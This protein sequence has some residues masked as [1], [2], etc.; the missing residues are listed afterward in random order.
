MFRGV[1]MVRSIG[2]RI[3]IALV[4]G[5][6]AAGT[7]AQD[8]SEARL[9]EGLDAYRAH[10]PLE[11]RDPLR[12]ATFGLL[13]RPRQ[14]CEALVYLALSEEA[15]GDHA[16]AQIAL[17]KLAE[18]ERRSPACAEANVDLQAR[19]DFQSQFR[20]RLFPRT[21]VSTAAAAPAASAPARLVAPAGPPAT[22]APS[23][24]VTPVGAP[25]LPAASAPT[26][27]A[28]T[29]AS[30]ATPAPP[31][32][33]RAPTPEPAPVPAPRDAIAG[34]DG[35]TPAR[36]KKSVPTIYPASARDARVGG[37]VIL[38][39]L[40]SETGKPLK[41]EVARGQREDLNAAAVASVQQW[42]FEPARR[43]GKEIQSLQ[44]IQIPFQP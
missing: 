33:R 10:R 5:G 39:V 23:R 37:T 43:N 6:V 29:V 20:R 19:A 34:S 15:A 17:D 7:R 25:A 18:A 9:K 8:F 32:A 12:V 44:M 36:V 1:G 22:A 38:R 2:F 28:T 13:D 42:L 11:A 24:L 4:V 41:V 30:A 21:T 14:R 16:E 3:S 31:P 35:L 40:V 27:P 26:K